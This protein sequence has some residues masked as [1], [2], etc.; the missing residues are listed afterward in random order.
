MKTTIKVMDY[1]YEIGDVICIG[2][3][4]VHYILFPKD[5]ESVAK[6]RLATEEMY[7]LYKERKLTVT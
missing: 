4:E 6:I 5:G 1:W 3:T 2:D 7:R